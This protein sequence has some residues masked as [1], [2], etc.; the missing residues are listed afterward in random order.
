[1][2]KYFIAVIL[3]S[4]QILAQTAGE[5]G[6][7]FLK[8]GFGARNIAMSDLGV[9]SANDISALHYN[10]ALLGLND[11]PEL[12]FSH[13][14][15]FQDLSSEM[16]GAGFNMF[17]LPFA[18]GVNTTSISNIEIRTRPGDPEGKF[19]ANYFYGS[20]SSAIK[21]SENIY[22][23]V[24]FKYIYENLYSDEANGYAF[25]FGLAYENI[26]KGLS[27]GAALKNIGS[28]NALRNISTQLPNDLRAGA[29][30]E[31]NLNHF[32]I[33]ATTG[34]QK[35]FQEDVIHYHAGAEAVYNET[36]ALRIGYASG[37]DSKILSF[38]FGVMLKNFRTDYAYVPV[39]FGLGDSHIITLI[40]TFN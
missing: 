35:Y 28:M 40:Y 39:K 20:M 18:F 1:M 5:S 29:N 15:L 8:N 2:K 34:I 3:L 23:G 10:P 17:G 24:T 12:T 22:G 26:I 6:L 16:V 38:G 31:I 11:K 14:S 19:N 25:D 36:F 9:I 4:V 37:Y 32:V 21:L 7:A 30:Y 33:N 13:N 27:I